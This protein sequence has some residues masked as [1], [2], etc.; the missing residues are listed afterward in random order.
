MTEGLKKIVRG[1]IRSQPFNRMAI[2]ALSPLTRRGTLPSGWFITHFPRIGTV[3]AKMPNGLFMK[4][5]SQFGDDPI[6]N[7]VEWLGWDASESEAIRLFFQLALKA[8]TILDIGA[9]VGY[10]ALVAALA[11]PKAR[12][13]C[14]E[15]VPELQ[16]RLR[17]NIELNRL[18]DRVTCVPAAVG[19]ADSST[20]FFRGG[21]AMPTCS[22]LSQSYALANCPIVK[23]ID[24]S[25]LR[26]DTWARAQGLERVY[27]IKIDVETGEPDVLIGMKSLLEKCSPD[28]ICEVLHTESTALRLEE[29]LKSYNYKFYLVT[30][31]GLQPAA[32]I[33]ANAQ[34]RNHLFSKRAINFPGTMTV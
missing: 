18:S 33:V 25:V 21:D 4:L 5:G 16:Q 7:Q 12:I 27:L 32:H 8:D 19:A 3:K 22:S 23:V 9:Y 30:K 1:I 13:F 29:I 24:V 6:A 26:L 11:N 2:S 17:H 20:Q 15:P 34:W 28:I 31:E 10:F 14:F